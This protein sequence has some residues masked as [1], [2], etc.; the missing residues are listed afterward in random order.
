MANKESDTLERMYELLPYYMKK[1]NNH[2]Y[3]KALS[4]IQD[5]IISQAINIMKQRNLNKAEGF[6]LDII[7]DIVA[8][9]RNMLDD[10]EYRKMIKL[11]IIIN[12]STGT[13]ENINNICKTFLGEDIYIGMKEGW[14]DVV[15]DNE[16]ALIRILL[17]AEEFHNDK[18]I[19]DKRYNITGATETSSLSQMGTA[20]NAYTMKDQEDYIP[21]TTRALTIVPF[22]KK[23]FP[24]G[25]RYQYG[26]NFKTNVIRVNTE[27]NL[28]WR[29]SQNKTIVNNE[30]NLNIKKY[31]NINI[32][33]EFRFNMTNGKKIAIKSN[34]P[35]YTRYSLLQAGTSQTSRAMG[36]VL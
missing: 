20:L 5:E 11:Q 33:N 27:S 25:V 35:T 24:I 34:A 7:G 21:D 29:S 8:L 16:P 14:N 36:I 17:R 13:I 10:E 32:N 1:H 22:L 12:N 26:V 15:T 9:P 4:I 28:K 18:I 30:R 2:I 19:T 6:A 31:Q 3:Y 23:T